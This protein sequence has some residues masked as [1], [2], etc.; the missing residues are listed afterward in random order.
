MGYISLTSVNWI[1]P[2][3]AA[4]A[5]TIKHRL[6][7]APDEAGSYTVDSNNKMI[8]PDGTIQG[9]PFNITGLADET[10][11]VVRVSSNCGGA[12]AEQEFTTGVVCPAISD[13]SGTGN[14]GN[15]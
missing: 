3:S 2:P 8:N 9:A 5:C 13:I 12:Y 6:A 14:A 7:S 10:A 4:N 11:Y 15:P 1:N